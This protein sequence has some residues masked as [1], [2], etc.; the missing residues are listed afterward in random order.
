MMSFLRGPIVRSFLVALVLAISPVLADT[1][2]NDDG[3]LDGN[4]QARVINVISEVVTFTTTVQVHGMYLD[5][6]TKHGIVNTSIESIEDQT[7]QFHF[8][9]W[10]S[11]KAETWYVDIACR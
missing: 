7:Y 10:D 11:A 6:A 8:Q 5:I 3:H 4:Y 1:L 9:C 2:N